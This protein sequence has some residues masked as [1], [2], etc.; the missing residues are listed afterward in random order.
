MPRDRA[1]KKLTA[2]IVSVID[3][4]LKFMKLFDFIIQFIRLIRNYKYLQ[5]NYFLI[6]IVDDERARDKIKF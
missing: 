6:Q 5:L 3:L 2:K 1:Y 4:F